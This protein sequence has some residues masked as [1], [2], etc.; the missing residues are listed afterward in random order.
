VLLEDATG[1]KERWV[2]GAA[3]NGAAAVAVRVEWTEGARRR[4]LALESA[5]LC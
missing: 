4:S 3:R 1:L 2:V 5:M